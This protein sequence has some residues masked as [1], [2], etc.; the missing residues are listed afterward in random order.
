[1]VPNHEVEVPDQGPPGL[2]ESQTGS[3]WH[4]PPCWGSAGGAFAAESQV[5]AE[6]Q[7]QVEVQSP[8]GLFWPIPRRA[9]TSGRICTSEDEFSI[10]MARIVFSWCPLVE[11]HCWNFMQASNKWTL[12]VPI[13]KFFYSAFKSLWYYLIE[14]IVCRY[15]KSSKLSSIIK[16]ILCQRH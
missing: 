7:S 1:M 16:F 8:T 9:I 12:S 13:K 14:N 10:H 3:L 4:E 6:P 15:D 5:W 2:R 11:N